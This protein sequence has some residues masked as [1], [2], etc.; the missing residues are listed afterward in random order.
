[1]GKRMRNGCDPRTAATRKMRVVPVR[2]R[3]A[4]P[5]PQGRKKRHLITSTCASRFAS[6]SHVSIN[7]SSSVTHVPCMTLSMK[8]GLA[9]ARLGVCNAAV[10]A[11]ERRNPG[12][13][14]NFVSTSRAFSFD[15]P[16]ECCR[17]KY[18]S[19]TT[20]SHTSTTRPLIQSPSSLVRTTVARGSGMPV[21][22]RR[23]TDVSTL[24]FTVRNPCAVLR[25]CCVLRPCR[26]GRQGQSRP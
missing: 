5:L 4:R 6:L 13:T 11:P 9:L 12:C 19:E 1:M 17:A 16:Y 2:S 3:Q 20:K 23:T 14:D 21:K 18:V 26:E 24:Y 8:P 7:D 15:S 25:C 22:T 10:T